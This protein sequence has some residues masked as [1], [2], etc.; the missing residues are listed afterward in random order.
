MDTHAVGAV[1]L[2]PETGDST[3]VAQSL[4]TSPEKKKR[5]PGFEPAKTSGVSGS[6]GTYGLWGDAYREMAAD[7]SKELGYTI[8]PRVVQSVTWVAKRK[9]FDPRMTEQTAAAV[10][11]TW[12]EYHAG[13][14][15]FEETQQHILRL[16]GGMDKPP[17]GVAQ[18]KVP[19]VRVVKP[20]A[21]PKS[22][23]KPQPPKPPKPPAE[24]AE[25]A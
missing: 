16:A 22:A 14:R 15:S 10:Q 2:R 24:A 4:A 8:E 18:P 21:P 13:T 6:S 3:S 7:L 23:K 17:D 12:Q 19:K 20:K 5:K 9:L 25:A 11:Q 1:L